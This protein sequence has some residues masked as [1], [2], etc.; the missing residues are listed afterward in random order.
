MPGSNLD[1]EVGTKFLSE[2]DDIIETTLTAQ[3]AQ[4]DYTTPVSL[5]SIKEGKSALTINVRSLLAN[6]SKVEEF[7]NTAKPTVAAL[8]EVWQVTKDFPGYQGEYITR[9]TKRGGGVALLIQEGTD[10]KPLS[11]A[12]TRNI[13]LIAVEIGNDVFISTYIPPNSSLTGAFEELQKHLPRGKQQTTILGDFNIDMGKDSF[14]APESSPTERFHDFCRANSLMPTIW[15]PTRITRT[16]ATTIDNIL[17][18]NPGNMTTG[19]FTTQIADHLTPFIIFHNKEKKKEI[20]KPKY[21]ESRPMNE[22]SFKALRDEL[23][24][25]NWNEVLVETNMDRKAERFNTVL[26]SALNKCCPKKRVK[27]NKNVHSMDESMTQGLLV[28]RKRKQKIFDK[29]IKTRDKDVLRYHTKYNTLYNILVR[30]SKKMTHEQKFKDK[31]RDARE[32]WQ[33][34][35]MILARNKKG[36]ADTIK[37]II[38]G[39]QTEDQQTVAEAFNKFFSSVGQNLVDEFTTEK[40][41]FK[42]F[43]PAPSV[44]ELKFLEMDD[45]DYHRIIQSMKAKKSTGF[46][47]VSNRLIKEVQNQIKVPLM[48][49]INSSL[50]S[51]IVPSSWKVAKIIPLHK[52]GD[53]TDMNNYRPISLLSALSKV[54]E[55]VVH[56]QTYN[57]V[58]NKILSVS[59]FGFRKQ[60]ETTQAIMAFMKNM[61]DQENKKYHMAIF[62][63]IKKAFDTVSHELLLQK[64]HILGIREAENE[65]FRNYLTGRTQSTVL[66]SRRSQQEE[67]TCGVPQGSILGPLLFLL[68]IN[69]MPRA[70]EF[71]SILFADDTTYQVS[72]DSLVE[73]NRLANIEL[74]KAEEWFQANYLTLHPKKTRYILFQGT[75]KHTMPESDINIY[76]MG[77]K[78]SRVGDNEPEKAFKFLGLWIDEHLNWKHHIKKTVAK[79]RQMTY[80]MMQLKRF[81]SREH[82]TII[83]RGLI[84]PI[85]EYGIAVWGHAINRELNKA[86]KKY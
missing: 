27:F 9:T 70:T 39:K 42:Q 43:M 65:W 15:K 63:D 25:T 19:I 17:T 79:T 21:V 50:C 29:W 8:Q 44:S 20:L 16:T 74:K 52:G 6:G 28:S 59:Q 34:T 38:A 81:I 4:L 40:T 75:K 61:K 33:Y 57:F 32:M 11:R 30:K 12:C 45:T 31:Y 53:R 22:D 49:I 37:L 7:L 60:R 68:Y 85:I 83:Y 84:K 82:Q 35:N 72:A 62:I 26:L 36:K 66:G 77:Q 46:D 55:K 80:S 13:E 54:L 71:L 47:E 64:L 73:L 18:T 78:V 69:D 14:Q 86:H 24:V 23:A 10:Y 58:E 1:A 41:A 3:L 67:I 51:S 2:N 5:E 48:D 56:H 76:L